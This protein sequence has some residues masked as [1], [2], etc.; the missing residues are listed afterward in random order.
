MS[1]TSEIIARL[2]AAGTPFKG[3]AG[4]AEFSAIEKRPGISPAA[5]VM[6]SDEAAGENTRATGGVL[7]ELET[8][9]TIVLVAE[10]LSDARMAASAGDIEILKDWSRGQ[11]VGFQPQAAEDFLTLVSGKLLK[12]RSGTLWWEEIYAATQFLKGSS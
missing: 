2:S 8:D 10:N 3:V 9:I 4:A 7:Q 1:L 11:L 6:I 12:A 5:Y